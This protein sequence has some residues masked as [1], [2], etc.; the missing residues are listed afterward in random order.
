M[1]TFRQF[2]QILVEGRYASEHG[3]RKVWNEFR[4]NKTIRTSL[5]Q[6]IDLLNNKN[7][8]DDDKEEAERLMASAAA[9]MRSRIERAKEDPEDPLNFNHDTVKSG[10]FKNGKTDDDAESYYNEL[11]NNIDAVAYSAREKKMRAA[12]KDGWKMVTAGKKQGELS[13][14]ALRGG[15]EPYQQPKK[16][17][18]NGKKET[19]KQ[20]KDRLD[21]E[22]KASYQGVTSGTSKSDNVLIDPTPSK[23][24]EGEKKDPSNQD[25]LINPLNRTDKESD[26]DHDYKKIGVSHKQ[27]ANTQIAGGE[28]GELRGV[29]AVVAKRASM[30]FPKGTERNNEY[31]RVF[32]MFRNIANTTDYR[33]SDPNQI[34][35]RKAAAQQIWNRMSDEDPKTLQDFTQAQASRGGVFN[36]T[37]GGDMRDATAGIM[38]KV[39]ATGK[40]QQGSSNKPVSQQGGIIPRPTKSKGGDE[41]NRPMANRQ[42]GGTANKLGKHEQPF[43]AFFPLAQQIAIRNRAL[44]NN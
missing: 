15:A 20:Y 13:K 32:N 35:R 18:I 1:R 43:K 2:N 27:G 12:V 21:R 31:D 33:G 23:P 7:A 41:G 11:E 25:P 6:A 16:R 24:K 29:G 42:L 3:H 5:G 4:H 34:R 19:D 10:N 44:D 8:S 9:H 40:P 17:E 28:P 22:E 37:T 26:I 36:K 30:K 39:P 38:T 14:T